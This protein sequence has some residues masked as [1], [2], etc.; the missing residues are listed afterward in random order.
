MGG[1]NEIEK[2]PH[3]YAGEYLQALESGDKAGAVR[4]WESVPPHLLDM[5]KDHVTSNREINKY[6]GEK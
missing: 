3:H 4:I 5:V 1:L 2:R 6:R